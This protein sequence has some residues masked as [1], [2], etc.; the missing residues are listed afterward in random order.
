MSIS[1]KLRNSI[2]YDSDGGRWAGQHDR[3]RYQPEVLKRLLDAYH[4]QV[5]FVVASPED[6]QEILGIKDTLA[7][8]TSRIVLMPEG[9]NADSLRD[10]GLWLAE[11]CK[12]HGFRY[13]TRLHV[14][15]WGDKRGV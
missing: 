7:I 3:R 11:C 14:Q 10:R 4:Y 12:E 15:L 8:P 1:P 9:T 6:I 5:K 13:S 2:P